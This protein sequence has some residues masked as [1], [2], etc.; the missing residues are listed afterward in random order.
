MPTIN[1]PWAIV[2]CR[3]NDVAAVP[4]QR[5]YYEDLFTRNGTGGLC[6]YWRAATCNS[7]DLTGSSVF[8][9]FTMNHSSSEVGRLRFPGDRSVLVRWGLETAAANGVDV[10]RFR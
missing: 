8:G 6:D 7:L 3:F 2:L 1:W 5:D 9:W 4:Q 10:G